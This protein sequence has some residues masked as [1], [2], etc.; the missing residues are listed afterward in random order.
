MYKFVFTVVDI[1]R[2]AFSARELSLDPLTPLIILS[3]TIQIVCEYVPSK[4]IIERTE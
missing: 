3:L 2:M 1:S 4:M